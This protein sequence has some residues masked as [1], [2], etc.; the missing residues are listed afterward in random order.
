LIFY[1]NAGEIRRESRKGNCGIICFEEIAVI[2]EAQLEIWSSQGKTGQFTDTYNSIR[3]NLLDNSAPYP[4]GECEVFLQGSY[5]ND[6]NVFGDSDVDI[7]LKHNG[8][9]YKDLSRLAP[10]HRQ[11]YD[12]AFGGGGVVDVYSAFKKDA[13]AYISRLYNKVAVGTKAVFI[14]GNNNRRDSDVLIT[15]QF[16][17]YYEFE[18]HAKQRY[19]EGVCF[20]TSGVVMVENF[21]KQHSDNCAAKH[22]NTKS[23]FK[24]MVRIFKNMRNAMM[25]KG[26]LAEGIAPS[27][28]IEGMLYNVPDGKFGG[29]YQ[30]TWIE[31]FNHIVTAKR[32]DL[33]CAN[34][35][36]WL[37]RDASPTS[38]P[39]ANFN[40]FTGALK[41]YWET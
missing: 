22:K 35:M 10:A 1:G 5:K 38:W 4:V 23:W 34:Y 29:T 17:R 27:Y 31:C 19:D 36:H 37:V 24:P 30:S 15:Q 2:A 41:K 32:D 25:E 28:F 18:S 12:A 16:R 7:V 6:T 9:F 26:L 33:V 14:P 8:T 3:P 21:P 20:F 11:A 39:V 13:V 40:T